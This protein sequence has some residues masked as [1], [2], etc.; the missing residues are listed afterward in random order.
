MEALLVGELRRDMGQMGG[1]IDAGACHAQV[2][3]DLA[4][5][6]DERGDQA[7]GAVADVFVLAFFGFARF[8]QDAW[9]VFA[10]GFACRFF[11]RV[12]MTNSPC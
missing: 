3:H 8:D 4:G 11:R 7:T 10:G 2:P 1:E 9:D 12:Q 5:G 6:D